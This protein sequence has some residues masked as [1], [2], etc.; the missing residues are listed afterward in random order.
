MLTP[1]SPDL[2]A[3]RYLVRSRPGHHSFSSRLLLE[4][5]ED[6]LAPA[7]FTVAN[8]NDAGS[9]S[10]RAAIA[11]ANSAPGADLIAF[12]IP[13]TGAHTINLASALPAITGKVTIN[14]Q[15]QP[16]FNPATD[17]P[18]IELNGVA[19]GSNGEGLFVS[20]TGSGTVIRGLVINRFGFN[21]IRILANDCR[22]K[23]CYIGTDKTGTVG[24]GNGNGIMIREGAQG[25]LI[26]GTVVDARNVISGN[27][28]GIVLSDSGTSFND[29][30]GNR[31]GTDRTG[32]LD[33][34][35][36]NNGVYITAEASNNSIGSALAG[37]RNVISGNDGNGVQILNNLTNGNRVQG[38][39]IGTDKTG[40][41]DLG[42]TWHGVVIGDLASGNVIGGAAAG[43]GNVISGNDHSGVVITG[44]WTGGNRVRGNRIG[45]AAASGAALGNGHSGVLIESGAGDNDIGG[46]GAGAGN[47]IAFNGFDGVWISSGY[48]NSVLGNSIFANTQLGID[49]GTAGWAANDLNDPDD[50]A[51]TLLNYPELTSAKLTASGLRINGQVNTPTNRTLRIEFF[52]SNK[53]DSSNHGEGARFLGAITVQTGTGNTAQF[54]TLFAATGVLPG[55]VITATATDQF[56]NTSEFSLARTVT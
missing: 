26:G 56:G 31:I 27:N 36:V 48:G 21:G 35:N 45:V 50:G 22:V 55:Q 1:Y 4:S 38:N 28:H 51:N 44:T 10:L 11:T 42:N 24:L 8:A 19:T 41:V 49:L 32:T 25:N 16:G 52:A 14:G 29:V 6:R 17:R 3:R 46:T 37:A 23:A 39:Y 9:G 40:A 12:N 13:G 2:P 7:T 47:V 43:A 30:L 54:L 5:L 33:L 34:G 53:S 20:A 15:T 18:I